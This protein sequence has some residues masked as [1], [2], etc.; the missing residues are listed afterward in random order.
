VKWAQMLFAYVFTA[1]RDE[2][3]FFEL[4]K[5]IIFRIISWIRIHHWKVKEKYL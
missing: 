4:I 3:H 1:S 2:S 5:T